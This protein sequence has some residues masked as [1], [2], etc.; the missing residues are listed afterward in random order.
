MIVVV[1]YNVGNLG[2]IRNML[3]K[4]GHPCE[5]TSNPAEV[6]Q[7][8][9]IILPGVGPFDQGM[10]KLRALGLEDV[11]HHKAMRECVPLLG[12]CL[13]AQLMT[14]Q[15]EEGER[16]PGFGWVPGRTVR[17]APGRDTTA[18]KIPSMGWSGVTVRKPH[19][20]FENMHEDPR[21]Y[22]VHS[23][24]FELDRP[25]D[26]LTVSRYGYEFASA[27]A[28]DNVWGVQFHPEKS[29]KFGMRLLD[30]FATADCDAPAACG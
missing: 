8:S 27:F 7:A 11:L 10:R 15:S 24:H 29:H 16:E 5:V 6:E 22:F 2:S 28:R 18:L 4:L 23:Y 25:E 21:F 13:G 3:R 9:R 12:I 19:P 20:L 14:E 30:N 1:D 26:V 17:F